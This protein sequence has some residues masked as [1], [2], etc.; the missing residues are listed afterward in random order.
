ML[1]RKNSN[2]VKYFMFSTKTPNDTMCLL[3]LT[4][5]SA[6]ASFMEN[7]NYNQMFSFNDMILIM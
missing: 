3:Y 6:N 7:G 2:F 4:Q 5:G 1:N